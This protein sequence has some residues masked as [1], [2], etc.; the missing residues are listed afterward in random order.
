MTAEVD[1]LLDVTLDDLEDLPAFVVFPPGAH[2]CLAT[3][4]QKKIGEKPAVELKLKLVEHIELA[5][6]AEEPCAAGDE[7]SSLFFLDNVFGRG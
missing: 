5:D 3:L 1:N 7:S 6:G 4:E 2:L